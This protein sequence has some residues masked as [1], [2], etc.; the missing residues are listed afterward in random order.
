MVVIGRGGHDR[1]AVA[2]RPCFPTLSGHRDWVRSVAFSSDGK[3]LVSGSNDNTVK[4]WDV[5]TG[6]VVKTFHSDDYQFLSVSISAD[7]TRIASG[8]YR[9]IHLWDIQTGE[10]HWIMEQQDEVKHVSFSPTDP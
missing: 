2:R 5:Q 9:K 3:S 8:S 7:C 10:C 4:L 1:V 6:G